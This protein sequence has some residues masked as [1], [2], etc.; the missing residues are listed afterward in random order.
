MKFKVVTTE[1]TDLQRRALL[2]IHLK[3]KVVTTY[4]SYLRRYSSLDIHL[5]FKIVTTIISNGNIVSSWI[6][7]EIQGS[8]N[9]WIG[10]E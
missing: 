1:N 3:F 9:L 6:L 10:M 5:K 2:D 8:Y 4:F 7:L